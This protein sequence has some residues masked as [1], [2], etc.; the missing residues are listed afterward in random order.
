M[1]YAPPLSGPLD[2]SPL[3]RLVSGDSWQ[4]ELAH[5]RDCHLLIWVTRGQG[6]ALL[7]GQRRGFGPHTVLSIPARS[8]FSLEV[9]RQS[10]G[11][12]LRIGETMPCALPDQ[13]M[14]M[15]IGDMQEQARLNTL[16]EATQ[17]EQQLGDTHSPRAIL[18]YGELIGIH[19]QRLWAAAPENGK[20]S[21]ARRL[22][23]AFCQRLAADSE[24]VFNMA[25]HAAELGVT[26]TH[27]TRVCKQET[28]KTAAALLTERQLH[29]ARSLLVRTS[30]PM[31]DI[32]HS[33]GFGSAAYFTRFITQHTGETPSALRK[34]ARESARPAALAS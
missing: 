5:E 27:L 1:S 13:P 7:D 33:L 25:G 3:L 12:V 22:S 34:M 18:S 15:R 16:F 24:G 9:G 10:I 23:R 28:G 6:R 14:Q 2:V 31:R 32:A 8:L 26:P 29:A 30:L 21:A 4:V 17:R 20:V 19:L 11:Q